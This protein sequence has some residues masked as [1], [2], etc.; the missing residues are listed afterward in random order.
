MQAIL[1]GE[2]ALSSPVTDTSLG[3]IS[4]LG[5]AATDFFVEDDSDRAARKLAQ[6]GKDLLIP[7]LWQ[8]EYSV[9]SRAMD[10]LMWELDPAYMTDRERRW[11]REGRMQ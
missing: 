8:L 10:Y 7:N 5:S 6:L 4:T 3:L 1:E 9:T 2:T 11:V